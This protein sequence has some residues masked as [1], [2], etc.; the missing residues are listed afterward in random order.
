MRR[1]SGVCVPAKNAFDV[2]AADR[3]EPA[4]AHARKIMGN[5]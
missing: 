1:A 4:C 2:A 5:G 3:D